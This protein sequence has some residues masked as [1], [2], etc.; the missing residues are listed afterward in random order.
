MRTALV[1]AFLIGVGSPRFALAQ[2]SP[3]SSEESWPPRMEGAPAPGSVLPVPGSVFVHID[4][5]APVDLER[6][7][8]DRNNPSTI[9]CTSPCDRWLPATSGYH[10]TGDGTRASDRFE[11]LA[12][13]G[14]RETLVVSPTSSSAFGLGIVLIVVGAVAIGI[15]SLALLGAALPSDSP[16]GSSVNGTAVL[17]V[18]LILAGGLAAEGGGIALAVLNR[19]AHVRQTTAIGPTAFEPSARSWFPLFPPDAEHRGAPIPGYPRAASWPVLR[20]TF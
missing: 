5:P 16:N 1:A 10:I 3:P 20:L 17:E 13:A 15:A 19:S 11:L 18:G 2:S 14:G 4:S 12:N 8:G 6:E 9:M 7:T